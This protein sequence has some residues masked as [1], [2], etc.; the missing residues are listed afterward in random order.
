MS[1]KVQFM[2]DYCILQDLETRETLAIAWK[3]NGLYKLNNASYDIYYLQK[4]N[5]C[6]NVVEK[7]EMPYL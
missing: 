5:W 7:I 6:F 1:V 2:P 3:S 4:I